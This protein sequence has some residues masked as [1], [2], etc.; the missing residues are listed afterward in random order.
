MSSSASP[1]IVEAYRY[2]RNL[3][4]EQAKN[5]YFAFITLPPKQRS[6]IYASYAFCRLCDDITDGSD[7]SIE[8]QAHALEG[9]RSDLGAAYEGHS[10]GPV[11]PAVMD[12]ARTFD[13]PREYLDDIVRGVQ[14]DLIKRRYQTFE[15]LREYCYGVASTVGLVCI[16]IFGYKDPAARE[17]AIDLGLAMQLTNILRDLQEDAQRDRVYLPQDELTR[18]GYS[19]EDLINGVTNDRFRDLMAFQAGRARSLFL[20]GR[21]LLPLLPIRSRACVSVL[22]GLYSRILDRIEAR[23]YDVFSERVGLSTPSKLALTLRLWTK[24]LLWDSILRR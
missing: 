10:S 13:I 15:E 22:E 2:C 12:S 18:F 1:T 14:V 3:T 21:K 4:R 9:L 19:D 16:Q 11:F 7:L 8:Q 23:N 17:Y 5:F 20:N 6:A 24:S